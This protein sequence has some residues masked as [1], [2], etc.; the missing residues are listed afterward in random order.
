[1]LLSL[2]R[3]CGHAI[4]FEKQTRQLILMHCIAPAPC[5]PCTHE[6]QCVHACVGS[7]MCA[8][9]RLHSHGTKISQLK[10]PGWPVGPG[11]NRH[12]GGLIL[13]ARAPVSCRT[14]RLSVR[15]EEAHIWR[16]ANDKI[17]VAIMCLP[18]Q[19]TPCSSLTSFQT[20]PN[21]PCTGPS[22]YGHTAR[23]STLRE[24]IS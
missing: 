3:H 23:P 5:T 15:H 16:P 12:R 20:T 10:A 14:S 21:H 2:A 13:D 22:P 11:P 24:D 4:S 18:I 17:D 1:M 19:P 8:A 7:C 9:R 6:H